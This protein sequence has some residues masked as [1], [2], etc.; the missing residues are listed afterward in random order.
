MEA[1]PIRITAGSRQEGKTM[2][3]E[4]RLQQIAKR[5]YDMIDPW[6][7]EFTIDELAQ[8]I[9]AD[10]LATIEGLLDSIEEG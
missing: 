7:R 10:P 4:N 8:D 5:I 1:Q 6:E 3:D 9:T 2:N